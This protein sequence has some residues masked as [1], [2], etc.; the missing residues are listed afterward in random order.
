MSAAQR[1]GSSLYFARLSGKTETGSAQTA[2][3]TR[4]SGRGG[5]GRRFR[6]YEVPPLA[7]QGSGGRFDGAPGA[8]I[9]ELHWA[10]VAERRVRLLAVADPPI[11]CARAAA[12]SSTIAQAIGQAASTESAILSASQSPPPSQTIRRR[13]NAGRPSDAPNRRASRCS[14]AKCR[15]RR[16]AWSR[17]GH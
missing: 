6:A 16:P 15:A 2:H 13:W 11:P 17:Q 8:F 5:E 9:P 12:P 4:Q 10:Q 3:T 7:G 14:A 1:T